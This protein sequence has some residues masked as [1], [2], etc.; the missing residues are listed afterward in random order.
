MS[1]KRESKPKPEALYQLTLTHTQAWTLRNLCELAARLGMG[2][3]DMLAEY[4]P[5]PNDTFPP[6]FLKKEIEAMQSRWRVQY[7]GLDDERASWGAG[8]VDTDAAI[9]WDIYTCIR[10]RLAHDNADE[11]GD[12]HWSVSFHDPDNT[13]KSAVMAKIVRI[14]PE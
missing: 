5:H 1:A 6:R 10:H 9:A 13:A 2:Q 8:Q 3:L 14:A 7:F 4:L 12:K 11:T